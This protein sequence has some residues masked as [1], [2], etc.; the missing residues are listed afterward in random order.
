MPTY[1]YECETCGYS[2]EEFQQMTADPIDICPKC[3]E[4]NVRRLIGKGAGI[5]F[6]GPGFYATD[7]KNTSGKPESCCSEKKTEKSGSCP[8]RKCCSEDS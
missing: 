3:G 4:K 7:Y 2:F 5:I 8:A 6:K 1:E